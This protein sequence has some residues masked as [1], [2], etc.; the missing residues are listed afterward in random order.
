MS[1]SK[2]ISAGHCQQL[3][4]QVELGGVNFAIWGRYAKEMEL[5]LF[6]HEQ[7]EQPEVIRLTAPLHRSGYYWHVHVAG[8]KAGQLYGWRIP[9]LLLAMP[10]NRWEADKV[11]LDPYAKRILLP[12]NYDRRRA[13]VP[14]SNLQGCPKSAVIDMADYDWEGVERPRHSLSASV[15][16]EMHIGG[17]TKDP[18]SGLPAPKRGTY[19]GVIDKIP[20][21][22]S[23]G[24]TAVEL[25]PIFQFD[26]QD[27]RPGKSNY[28][29]YS[30]IGFFAPHG[31][32]ACDKRVTGVLD[33]FRDMVK[34][35][36]KA[37]IEVILDVVYNHTAE[38]DD[39][40]PTLCY[41]GLDNSAFY[42][43]DESREHNTN[44]SGCGNTLNASHPMTKRMIT[45][46]LRF[47][48]EEMH[49]DG[50]RFDLAAILSRDKNGHPL[51]DPPTLLAID[52]DYNLA[53][54]KIFAEAWDASG[55]NQV[56]RMAGARWR[57]WN[58]HFRDDVRAFVKGDENMVSRLATRLCGSPDIYHA[59]YADPH[60]SLNFITCHDGFTLW[61]LVSYNH[62]H[63][64][65]NGEEN[66]D[67]V[68]DNL[69]WNHGVEGETDD[70]AIR[71]LRLRQ[72]K[73]LMTIN[74]LAVGTPMLLMGDEVLR[75]Q[76]GNNNAYCQDNPLSWMNW[77]PNAEGQEMLRFTRELL[78]YRALR[79][80][81][82]PELI[83]LSLALEQVRI[84]WHGI[85][86]YA[87]DWGKDS[88]SLGL[89]AYGSGHQVDYYAFF[90]AYWEDLEI[91]L[92]DPPHNPEG[93]WYR[94]LD[95]G[96]PAPD[97][98]NSHGR[99]L[100]PVGRRYPVKARS[101]LVLV[102]PTE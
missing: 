64:L 53:D 5:L 87:P 32:F 66:R 38:G 88:R 1:V 45:D 15:V 22:V 75:T 95:T 10:G 37:G 74:L 30:P 28:W 80:D 76:Q 48:K 55:L 68:N 98:I 7:D 67:G 21:L 86:P 41:R 24:V 49:V 18:S 44:Y 40:G 39:Q 19:A 34:A 83:S 94:M 6:A 97:D 56:G 33:E 29:G 11:L 96:L 63:N 59:P 101:V 54:T 4:A 100:V 92:P 89:T 42:I 3:G 93:Q 12:S 90:N 27:A 20:H 25:M 77:Q 9:S 70:P 85:Q 35:L 14:G 72:A 51:N 69:S 43:L 58:G 62:K 99:P 23:L 65:D 13:A 91:E 82:M 8:L 81:S 57:E 26:P 71:A 36:H 31:E 78:S 79:A 50:F 46:S 2:R 52:S 61:D 73:N 47:W 102:S 84:R 60:K 17:F 16:Y